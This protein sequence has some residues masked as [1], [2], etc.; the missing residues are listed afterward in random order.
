MCAEPAFVLKCTTMGN[1]SLGTKCGN[2][3]MWFFFFSFDLGDNMAI[4]GR[5]R[6]SSPT[7]NRDTAKT[8]LMS[9]ENLQKEMAFG[10]FRMW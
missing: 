3:E 1:I 10:H 5:W 9:A 4:R 2:T 8:K 7:W 6:S